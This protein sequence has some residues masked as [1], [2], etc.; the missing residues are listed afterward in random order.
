MVDKPE[1]NNTHEINNTE[2]Q[3]EEFQQYDAMARYVLSL[4]V[5]WCKNHLN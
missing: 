3:T 4:Q 5:F 1:T 2:Y